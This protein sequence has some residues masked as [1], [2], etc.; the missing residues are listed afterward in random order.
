MARKTAAKTKSQSAD[1][2]ETPPATP[3]VLP[4]EASFAMWVGALAFWWFGRRQRVAGTR[5]HAFWVEG[6]EPVC[7]GLISGA[8]LVGIG[9]AV[10]N[11]LLA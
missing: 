6:C 1:V 8:A 10:L 9:N 3:V 5:G 4:P 11:V 7:A 2:E